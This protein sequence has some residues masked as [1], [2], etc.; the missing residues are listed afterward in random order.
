MLGR[1]LWEVFGRGE[2][3]RL[4]VQAAIFEDMPCTVTAPL[5]EAVGRPDMSLFFR[6]AH[7][8]QQSQKLRMQSAAF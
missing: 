3:N 4:P 7:L 6:Q 5:Q 2:A 1:G 8:P